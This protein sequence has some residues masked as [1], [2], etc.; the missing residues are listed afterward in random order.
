MS[1]NIVLR[2]IQGL[3]LT[4]IFR[5]NGIRQFGSFAFREQHF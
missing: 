1:S 3:W 5:Q 2:G 4:K